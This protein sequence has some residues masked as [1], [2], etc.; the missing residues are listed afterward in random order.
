MVNK[1]DLLSDGEFTELINN[2]GSISNV[3][4]KL[5]YSTSGNSW[6]YEIVKERMNKLQLSFTKKSDTKTNKLNP[7]A[8]LENVMTS[9]S[10]YCRTKLKSRLFEEGLKEYKCEC[11]GLSEWMGKPISLQLHHIN[12]INN[13][14]RIE[15]LQILCPNCHAQTENFASK[16]RGTSIVRK[17]DNLPLEDKKLIM[18]TVREV[19][20]V[21][22]RKK[23]SFRNSL[24]N[25]VVKQNHDVIVMESPEETKEFGT[26]VEA[27]TYLFKELKIG[28]SIENNRS[29][30]SKCCSGSQKKIKGVYKFYKRSLGV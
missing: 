19:G 27:A 7:K 17:C 18:D 12:G 9:D 21:E 8:E 26:V 13:D 10:N 23:L 20:I 5:G 24:I 25:Q 6:G 28:E 4:S 1:I 11:C 2:S 29:A 15:N 16:G 22:A 30:I 3:L 14:N